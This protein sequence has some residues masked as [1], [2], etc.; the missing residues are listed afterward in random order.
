[1]TWWTY[2]LQHETNHQ[3]EL[4]IFLDVARSGLANQHHIFFSGLLGQACGGH[5]EQPICQIG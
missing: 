3:L 1:M 4:P 5:A 2:Y